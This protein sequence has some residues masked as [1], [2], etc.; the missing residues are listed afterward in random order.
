MAKRQ[1]VSTLVEDDATSP[2]LKAR[3]K[4]AEAI[5]VFAITELA[6]PDSGSYRSY[7]DVGKPYVTWNVVATPALSLT[8]KTWCFPVVG[9]VSYRGYFEEAEAVAYGD[10]LAAEKMDVAVVGARAYSTLGWFDDPI[11]STMIAEGD[12]ALGDLADVVLHETLHATFYIPGQS[13]L[14]ESVASFFG[15]Q[16]AAKYLEETVGTAAPE[17]QSFLE[18]RA[19]GE[20]RGRVMKTAYAQ[21]SALYKSRLPPAEKLAEKKRITDNLRAELQIKRPITNATLIQYKTYGSGKQE[22][23]DL[24][25]RCD[26]SFP[27]MLITLERLRPIAKVSRPHS[28]PGPMLR[29]LIA[30][31]CP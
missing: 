2:D 11:L 22:L 16:L 5:R 29:P 30:Q 18:G 8:P 4:Q 28:D 7:V 21:L 25:A 1:D 9:C 31:G 3:L 13:T 20:R 17:M 14:N 12:E 26:G 24:L 23:A 10:E 27:R 19:R 6:L 15:D